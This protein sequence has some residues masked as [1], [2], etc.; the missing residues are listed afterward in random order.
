MSSL[1]VDKYNPT[2]KPNIDKDNS[3]PNIKRLFSDIGEMFLLAKIDSMKADEST[4][5]QK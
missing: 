1:N 2:N 5:Q 3:L 4:E